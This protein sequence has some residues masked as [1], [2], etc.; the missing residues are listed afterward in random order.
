MP[1]AVWSARARKDLARLERKLA[2]RVHASVEQ[3]ASAGEGDVRIL[4]GRLRGIYRLRVG[5]W[6]AHFVRLDSGDLL[7]LRILPRGGAYRP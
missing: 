4:H 6:R 5:E 7:V 2:L 3:L 1:R